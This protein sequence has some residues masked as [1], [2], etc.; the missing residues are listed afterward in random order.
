MQS[1]KA[2]TTTSVAADSEITLSSVNATDNGSNDFNGFVEW[3]YD[4][5]WN[6]DLAWVTEEWVEASRGFGPGAIQVSATSQQT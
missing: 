6:I 3:A 1:A 4:D 2:D 5:G